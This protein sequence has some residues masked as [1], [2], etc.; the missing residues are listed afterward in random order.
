MFTSL[1][2]STYHDSFQLLLLAHISHLDPST[3]FFLIL[4]LKFNDSKTGKLCTSNSK[5]FEPSEQY[6]HRILIV[7]IPEIPMHFDIFFFQYI[8]LIFILTMPTIVLHVAFY[9]IGSLLNCYI[10]YFSF[11]H[12]SFMFSGKEIKPCVHH[13]ITMQNNLTGLKIQNKP[14]IK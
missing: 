7:F 14:I 1:N 8:L 4:E 10:I 11:V 2:L 5:D 12:Q 9:H 3:N 6:I 13:C